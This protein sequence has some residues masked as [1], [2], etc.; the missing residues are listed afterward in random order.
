MKML[1]TGLVSISFRD[2][3]TDE[4]I[5]MV[6]KAGLDAIEWGGDVHV[7]HGDVFKAEEVKQSCGLLG[8]NCPS[9]GSYYRV[10]EYVEPKEEFKKVLACAKTLDADV[11]RVW[12]GTKSTKDADEAYWNLITNELNLICRMAAQEGKDVALEYHAKTLTDNSV[13]T[14]KLIAKTDAGNLYTYW[15]PPVGLPHD[16]NLRD[17][18]MLKSHISNIH[19]FTWEGRERM[20]LSDGIEKWEEYFKLVNTWKLR[21][22][23][24][25]FIKDNS[26]DGFYRDAEILKMMVKPYNKI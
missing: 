8:I 4:I 6:K 3:T 1:K 14:M 24:L 21:Y 19:T 23:L 11:I 13:D 25:E 20:P 7:P 10:G 15:Q 16:R 12:A 22:C 17:I 9:Y 5:K 2:L 26:V 18:K